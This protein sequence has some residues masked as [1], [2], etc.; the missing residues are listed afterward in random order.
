MSDHTIR[1]V[2]DTISSHEMA[3]L[4]E[5]LLT[6]PRVTKGPL[7]LQFEEEWA[8]WQGCKYAV[9][10]N[11]G[12]SANF[13]MLLALA[14]TGRLRNKKIILPAV[15]WVTT[16]SPAIQLGFEPVLCDCDPNDLGLDIDDF[17]YLCKTENPSAVMLVHVLGHANKLAKIREICQQYGVLLLEDCCEAHGA[18]YEN[19]KVGNFGLMS[20]FSFYFGHHMSTIEGGAICTSDKELYNIL[21]SLRSHGWLRDMQP[22]VKEDIERKYG[23]SKF[24]STY[25]FIYPGLNFR[26]TDLNAFI[27]LMQLKNIDKTIAKRFQNFKLFEKYLKEKCMVQNS[28]S[29]LVSS[30]ALGIIT[31]HRDEIANNLMSNDIECRPLICGSIQRHPF[32]YE[33]YDLRELPN[34][35]RVHDMGLYV[36]CHQAMTAEDIRRVSDVI[37]DTIDRGEK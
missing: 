28:E 8:A 10:V 30:L 37:I 21:L 5:W 35:D 25:F 1:L 4:A 14:Q 33:N 24:Q 17:E 22:T 32:W 23:I 16:I 15:S 2:E 19:E 34:A 31:P 9:F 26:S 13:L 20:S 3:Q 36:P 11:S 7:T 18:Q 6:T 12:S 29:T 27:G